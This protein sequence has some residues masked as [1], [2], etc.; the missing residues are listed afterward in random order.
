MKYIRGTWNFTSY[1]GLPDKTKSLENRTIILTNQLNLVVFLIMI[2]LFG[3]TTT[4]NI[5]DKT[6]YGF[7]SYRLLMIMSLNVV[8]FILYYNKLHTISKICL[9]FIPA[10]VFLILPTL[11][12]FVEQES[13]FHYSFSIIGFS[14]L[15]QLILIPRK[16][17]MLYYSAMLFNLCYKFLLITF[18]L[19]L[20]LK[21]SL[22]L[23]FPRNRLLQIRNLGHFQ[24]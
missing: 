14:I 7:G 11:F 4:V 12:N 17:K 19:Y 20:L 21:S 2:I 5:V 8:I 16:N 3:V 24:L 10:I 18:L 9:I 13:Y 1:L 15:P 22:L 6:S 23:S